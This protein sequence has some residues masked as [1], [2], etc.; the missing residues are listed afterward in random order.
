MNAAASLLVFVV[1]GTPGLMAYFV[2]LLLLHARTDRVRG[3]NAMDHLLQHR[4]HALA[5]EWKAFFGATQRRAMSLAGRRPHRFLSIACLVALL[6]LT[7]ILG[8]RV[9]D[10][11]AVVAAA[12]R[13][14]IA[15][16]VSA[17]MR[18]ALFGLSRRTPVVFGIDG[19]RVR[20][21]FVAY[22]TVNRFARKP[23]GV[24]IERSAPLPSIFVPTSDPETAE[25]LVSYLSSER[26]RAVRWRAEPSPPLPAAGFRGSS[27]QV[28]W[29]VRLLDAGTAEERDAVIARVSPEELREVLDETA[30][31]A[32]EDA[33]HAHLRRGP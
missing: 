25:D 32:L 16:A 31:P 18:V 29:R 30:D 23:N 14:G 10:A 33:L 11:S 26:D 21:T 6:V 4:E 20:E 15:L 12:S 5:L 7:M 13:L 8:E 1:M 17:A 2:G 19:V 24:V 28:G 27:S 3:Y 22:S 9:G